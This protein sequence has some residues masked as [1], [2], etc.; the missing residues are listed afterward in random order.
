MESREDALDAADS[1]I[2]VHWWS[3]PPAKTFQ[4]LPDQLA[5][6]GLHRTEKDRLGTLWDVSLYRRD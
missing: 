2:W 1:V 3:T 4:P 6:A 5:A